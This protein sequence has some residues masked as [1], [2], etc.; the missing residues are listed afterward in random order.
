LRKARL[1]PSWRERHGD[2]SAVV[3]VDENQFAVV[4]GAKLFVS[5]QQLNPVTAR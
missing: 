1:G 5:V 2:A 4:S 3:R